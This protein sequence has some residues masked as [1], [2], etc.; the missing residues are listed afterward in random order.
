MF[1][2]DQILKSWLTFLLGSMVAARNNQAAREAAA[3]KRERE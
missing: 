2:F 3:T 1:L